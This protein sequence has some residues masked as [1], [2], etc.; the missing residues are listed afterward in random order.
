MSFGVIPIVFHGGGLSETV[1]YSF[2]GFLFKTRKELVN[3]LKYLIVSPDK[4]IEKMRM[5]A[6]ETSKHFTFANFKEKMELILKNYLN[7]NII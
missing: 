2:N 1:K 3:Y 4:D 5:N 6:K 7:Q